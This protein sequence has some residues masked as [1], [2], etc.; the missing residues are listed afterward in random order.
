MQKPTMLFNLLYGLGALHTSSQLD[1][2]RKTSSDPYPS[3][4]RLNHRVLGHV[5]C[6]QRHL[7]VADLHST[8]VRVRNEY[9]CKNCFDKLKINMKDRGVILTPRVHGKKKRGKHHGKI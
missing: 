8:I 5:R 6:S 9:L 1:R 3:N 7:S 4:K 2:E